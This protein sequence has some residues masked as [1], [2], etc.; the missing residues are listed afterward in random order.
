MATCI[1]FHLARFFLFEFRMV[2]LCFSSNGLDM[3]IFFWNY[4]RFCFGSEVTGNFAFRELGTLGCR[5]TIFTILPCARINCLRSLFIAV[6]SPFSPVWTL[7]EKLVSWHSIRNVST[8]IQPW[9][10]QLQTVLPQG[11]SA[12]GAWK[13]SNTALEACCHERK[14]DSQGIIHDHD[15]NIFSWRN[16]Y[17]R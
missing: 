11:N 13:K 8:F 15:D 7:I 3:L 5:Q 10:L 14:N 12:R 2:L 4:H 6:V 16:P 17:M 1:S 9:H